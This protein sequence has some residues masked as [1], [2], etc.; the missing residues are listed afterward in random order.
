MTTVQ[1]TNVGLDQATGNG[2]GTD[3][4]G[5]RVQFRVTDAERAQ[6]AQALYTDLN[7]NFSGVEVDE[8]DLVQEET[9][10]TYELFVTDGSVGTAFPADEGWTTER[11]AQVV[12]DTYGTNVPLVFV[13]RVLP[14][15][16]TTLGSKE[17]T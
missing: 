17:R 1:L 14:E 3:P 2:V 7:V 11:F 5:N 6:L 13:V 9:M 8:A 16:V 15:G 10:T 12:A 4:D